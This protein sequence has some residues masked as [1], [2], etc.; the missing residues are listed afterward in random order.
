MIPMGLYPYLVAVHITAVVCFVGTLLAQNRMMTQIACCPSHTRIA[1]IQSLL[2]VDRSV[3][4]PA[5]LTTWAAGLLLA[6]NGGWFASGWL[7]AKLVLVVALSAYHGVQ[8]GRMRR[9]L[10]QAQITPDGC[11]A[12]PAV[13]LAI[14]TRTSGIMIVATLAIVALAVVKPF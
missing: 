12:P 6:I 7:M 8:S 4:T 1:T 11:A 3:T 9:Q 13:P 10:S 5:L 2:R 14:S